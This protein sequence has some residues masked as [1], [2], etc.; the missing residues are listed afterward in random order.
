MQTLQFNEESLY[1]GNI[2][3]YTARLA[4]PLSRFVEN[5]AILTTY[6]NVNMDRSTFDR[7][8]QDID[9]LFGKHAPLRYDRIINFP[10]YG[11]DQANPTNSDEKQMEDI[12]VEGN[13]VILPSTLVPHEN[14]MF[15]VNHLQMRGIFQVKEV[16]YDSMKVEGYYQIR[17]ELKSTSDET[18]KNIENQTI[19]RYKFK[20]DA[21][22]T[23]L[24]P[25]INEDDYV[26][27]NEIESMVNTMID[28]YTSL[29]YNKRH[30]CFLYEDNQTG[31]RWFDF[32][33]NHFMAKHSL[34]NK[35]NNTN[36]IMLHHKLIDTRFNY[37]YERSVY[38]W[39]ER[40]AP[41]RFMN[42]FKFRFVD[43]IAYIDSSFYNWYEDDIMIA[44]PVHPICDTQ[45][46]YN[47]FNDKQLSLFDCP[48]EES[49]NEYET[50]IQKFINGTLFSINDISLYTA[51]ALMSSIYN[52]HQYFY[53]PIIIYIIRKVLSMN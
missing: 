8:I 52:P 12:N 40:D 38:K 50:I 48:C 30:N 32:C 18:F 9:N 31:T 20:P 44:L 45:I 16:I 10:L 21:V 15:I 49:M 22:G 36:V 13:A 25:I 17:Y 37:Y 14:D 43:G 2:N 6:Y 47:F 5:G 34:M 35:P 19:N 3:K 27:R 1:T 23:T 11:F 51:D 7:G 4:S 42:K 41:K 46:C 39:I 28:S 24:N 33:G 29:F 26:K 53:T